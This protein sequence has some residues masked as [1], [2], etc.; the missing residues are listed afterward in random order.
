MEDNIFGRNLR[1]LRNLKGLSLNALGKELGVTGSAISSWELGNKEPNFDMLIKV[2]NYFKVSIDYMLNHQVFDNEAQ[3]KEVVSQLANEI[4]ERY[5]NI[6]DSKKPMVKQEL[7]K[8]VN[9]LNFTAHAED[10]E[11]KK[12]KEN[13]EDHN[14]K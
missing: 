9:Y 14:E 7:I 1:N 5:K 6:P 8:Y 3:K 13:N 2:A 4:Y 12:I 10:E 11:L